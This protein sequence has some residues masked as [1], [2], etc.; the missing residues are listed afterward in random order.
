MVTG[1]VWKGTAFGGVKGRSEVP[2]LVEAAMRGEIPLDSFITHRYKG[3]DTLN[4]TSLSLLPQTLTFVSILPQSLS[5]RTGCLRLLN[6]T[7]LLGLEGPHLLREERATE[8]NRRGLHFM[9]SHL[10]P[11]P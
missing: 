4:D 6:D 7:Q 10:P 5:V 3:I 2:G 1:R 11:H 8:L 9:T